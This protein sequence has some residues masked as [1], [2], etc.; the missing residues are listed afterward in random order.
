MRGRGMYFRALKEDMIAGVKELEE[1]IGGLQYVKDDIYYEPKFLIYNSIGD[2]PEIG[3]I[4]IGTY[5]D[6]FYSQ[7]RYFV[8]KKNEKFEYERFEFSKGGCRYDLKNTQGTI[9]FKPSG[10]YYETN[11]IMPGEITT[12]S[13]DE[14]AQFLFKEFKK[15]LQKNMMLGKGVEY[16][17]KSIIKNKEKYR[18]PYGS[19]SSP[20]EYDL[21]ISDLVWIE[22]GR[23]KK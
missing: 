21:D 22:K 16:I 8:L 20:P 2:L 13:E 15:A 1:K 7:W 3:L 10:I 12:I 4:R 5:N 19:P 23:K 17:G 6:I 14:R 11:S 18:L 9:I